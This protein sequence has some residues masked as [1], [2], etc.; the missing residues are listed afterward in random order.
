MMIFKET[1]NQRLC[2][3]NMPGAES[4][5]GHVQKYR[6]LHGCTGNWRFARYIDAMVLIDAYSNKP[7]SFSRGQADGRI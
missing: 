5:E 4:P 3:R 2:W 7:N 6:F 1:L